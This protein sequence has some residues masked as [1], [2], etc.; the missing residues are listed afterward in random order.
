MRKAWPAPATARIAPSIQHGYVFEVP[1][2]GVSDAKPIK[3]MGCFVHEAVAVDPRTGIVY[4][5]QDSAQA[6]LYRYI[7]KTRGRLSEGGRL[8]ML[9]VDGRRNFDTSRGQRAGSA[10]DIH[11]VDIAEPDRPH[12]SASSGYGLGVLQQG[13]DRGGAMFSRLEGATFGDGRLYV[14]ATGRRRGAAW[15]RCGRSIHAAN[16]CGWSFESPG[17]P[18]LNMPDNIALSPRGGLV[19]CEDGTADAYVHGLTRDGRIF[20]FARNNIRI[21]DAAQRADGR[22]QPAGV[23]R[24]DLQP[25]WSLAVLQR[26]DARDYVRRHGTVG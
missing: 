15:V 9:A 20:R 12:L 2:D 4:Q 21:D 23:R 8:Q 1:H 13:I 14:T 6:G 18:V 22:L 24:R 19:L 26:A 7:P 17:A 10:Y 3:A 11:W 16:D 25:G 5:T